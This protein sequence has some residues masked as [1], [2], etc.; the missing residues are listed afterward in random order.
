[1][2]YSHNNKEKVRETINKSMPVFENLLS[3]KDWNKVTNDYI[4][5]A[6]VI[7]NKNV[8]ISSCLMDL[9]I[10]SLGETEI[11][12]ANKET[13]IAI[14]AE[15]TKALA[16]CDKHPSL[17]N[18]VK[19]II[20]KSIMEIDVGITTP[21]SAFK[22]WINELFVFN[23]LAGWD[24]YEIVDLE[25]SLGSRNTCD[26]VC[27]NSEN[28]EI[29]FEVITLQRLIP[30]KQDNSTTMNEFINGR[31]KR[32]YQEKIEGIRPEDLPNIRILPVV[33]YVAG[34]E[35]FDISLKSDIATEPFA[36]MKN[37]LD[38]V[39]CVELLPLNIYLS[40]IRAQQGQV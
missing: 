33:E 2:Y 20:R 17:L 14:N 38:G 3:N 15:I 37:S 4:K 24:G 27:R 26:F 39:M 32:K 7:P 25:R 29:W 23:L 22:N 9:I 30:S 11:A 1:M 28:E 18:K 21:N 35:R 34:L 6:N 13:I 31:I 10:C 36:I 12:K 5:R 19:D 16:Y 40:K 8:T